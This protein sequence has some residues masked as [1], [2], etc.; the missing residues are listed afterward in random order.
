[1]KIFFLERS[2]VAFL[3]HTVRALSSELFSTGFGVVGL[4]LFSCLSV[5]SKLCKSKLKDSEFACNIYEYML[6]HMNTYQYI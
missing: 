4:L 3:H 2:K 5:T 1:M 6:I